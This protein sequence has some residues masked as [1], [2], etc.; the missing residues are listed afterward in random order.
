MRAARQTPVDDIERHDVVLRFELAI[1]RMKVR[2][3]I[4]SQ[5][6]RMR[7]PKNSLMVGIA[8]LGA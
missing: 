2:R 4:S 5:Y 7:M 3:R 8:V 6:I 1:D